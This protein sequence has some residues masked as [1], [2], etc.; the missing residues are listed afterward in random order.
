MSEF[1]GGQA[2][3]EGVMMRN[4]HRQA[5]AVRDASGKIVVEVTPL[6]PLGKKIPL[7]RLP[8]LRGIAAL[9]DALS[10]SIS[11]LGRS[12]QILEPEE[13]I[14]GK[15]LAIATG[16]ALIFAVGLFF[17]LPAVAV[18]PLHRLGWGTVALNFCEGLVRIVILVAY[19]AAVNLLRDI[20]RTFAY[21]GAEHKAIHCWEQRS[22]P[23]DIESALGCSR[24]HPRCGTSF[25]LL[26][27]ISGI[28]VFSLFSPPNLLGR[29][30]LRIGLLPLLAG[31]AYELIRWTAASSSVAARIAMLPGLA[32]QRLT[33]R[34][35]DSRQVEVALAALQAVV[36][37][38]GGWGYNNA[39]SDSSGREV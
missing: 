27:V 17:V 10:G 3:L 14:G 15:E 38:D 32:L 35:P 8:I 25:L 2:V 9:V 26:V 39:D 16:L 29:I 7:L 5:L 34:E 31:V 23:P 30:A 11:A 18:Q 28:L 37:P 19:L 13:E 36:D 21:H 24:F 6:T 22:Q 20:R 12:A 4:L 33:T 1:V